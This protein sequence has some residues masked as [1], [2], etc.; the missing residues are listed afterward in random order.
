MRN[1]KWASML[2]L[3]LTL[4]LL[5]PAGA[6]GEVTYDSPDLAWKKDTNP[7][8]FSLFFNMTWAPFDVWGTDHVSQ[9]VTQDTGISFEASKSQDANQLATIV[10][11]GQLPDAIF[12]YG[13]ANID[14]LEDES[15]CYPWDELIPQYAP[16]FM[17][18][19]DPSEIAMATR[20]DGHFYTLYTHVRNQDYWDDPTKGVDVATRREM[21]NFL[22]NAADR[23]MTVV[24]VSSDNDELLDVCDRIYVFFEGSI[25]AVLEGENKTEER[26]VSAM[27]GL[28]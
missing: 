1:R 17:D 22:Q 25:H 16:E 10:A 3:L 18:L 28:D 19:I 15:V 21:H 2:A 8:T 9:Q 13:A 5:L 26:F 7:A 4:A 20:E 11:S 14:L 24:M 27:L 23:G 6:L 12:I